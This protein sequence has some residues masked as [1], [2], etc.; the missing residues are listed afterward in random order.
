[1]QIESDTTRSSE[2]SNST[3][4]AKERRQLSAP[5]IPFPSDGLPAIVM[6]LIFYTVGVSFAFILGFTIPLLVWLSTLLTA[7]FVLGCALAHRNGW[8]KIATWLG[9]NAIVY[10]QGLPSMLILISF[11]T[12]PQPWADDW[13]SRV[14]ARMGFHAP[15]VIFALAPFRD[16]IWPA[17]L[18]FGLQPIFI[19]PLLS[20][21]DQKRCWVYV[22]S[23]VVAMSI[24]CLL[25]AF[26]PALGTFRYFGIAPTTLPPFTYES[27]PYTF[28]H[29]LML[30]RS[31][32]R[33]VTPS[34]LSGLVSFPSYHAVSATLAV[35][36]VLR[37]PLLLGPTLFLNAMLI[38]GCFFFGAHYLVDVI[39]GVLIA[40]IS[41][42]IADRI[43]HFGPY[44][45]RLPK[46]FQ[47][48]SR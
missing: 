18:S 8:N 31:G 9:T 40:A 39:A 45:Q 30:L 33:V 37:F 36:S 4:Y 32:Y 12:F 47:L 14:D 27:A 3:N 19:L 17:Y 28:G 13:L 15:D 10:G 35:W 1:M 22:T 6:L 24:T 43:T 42:F 41:I 44:L 23:G 34:I 25:F 20:I 48:G 2:A 5:A 29:A 7:I 38:A 11:A 26:T 46:H 21:F 16:L